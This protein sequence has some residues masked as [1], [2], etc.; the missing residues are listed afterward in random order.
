MTAE[1]QEIKFF[2]HDLRVQKFLHHLL[3]IHKSLMDCYAEH[4]LD[5]TLNRHHDYIDRLRGALSRAHEKRGTYEV[6]VKS[7]GESAEVIQS[8]RDYIESTLEA[9]RIGLLPHWR[10][11]EP[12]VREL[13][14]DALCR[15]LE[16]RFNEVKAWIGA[17]D[18]RIV[19]FVRFRDQE[20]PM[21]PVAMSSKIRQYV[22]GQLRYYVRAAG[23]KRLE[24]RLGRL[25]PGYVYADRPRFNR[26]LFNLTMNACDAMRHKRIGTILVEV[27]STDT[28]VSLEVTDEGTGMSPEKVE[29]ILHDTKDL[30][31][32]L[33]S[34]GFMFVRQTVK[35]FNG[36]IYVD[37]VVGKGTKIKIAFPRYHVEED[38]GSLQ[39]IPETHDPTGEAIA[40][41]ERAKHHVK[42]ADQAGKIVVDDYCKSLAPL[43]GCLFSIGVHP[44]TGLVDHF[45]HKAYDPDWMMGHDDLAPM[46]FE[47][48]FRGR[49]ETDDKCGTAL[50]L[51][52]PHKMDEYYDLRKTPEAERSRRPYLRLIHN[53]YVLIA[54]HL[55]ESGM[56]GTTMVYIT[57]LEQCFSK[58][59]QSF[60]GDPFPLTELAQQQLVDLH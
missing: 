55:I 45:V 18:R 14:Q 54:R 31:G 38:E 49:Y 1:E 39:P 51:K 29:E 58:V 52:S 5:D 7:R 33:H 40:V 26:L 17:I 47:A 24:I 12:F 30:K 32:E 35:A 57:N 20:V 19:N 48:V 27:R 56:D 9:C 13:P 59:G 25:D 43:P 3:N 28:V 60:S 22:D 4:G 46:L 44:D 15:K 16:S 6:T 42:N 2:I 11:W 37:S 50:I 41:L 10:D 8:G 53:E 34:L 21:E 36:K 23:S